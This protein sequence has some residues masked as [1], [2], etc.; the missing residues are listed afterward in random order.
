[1][2]LTIPARFPLA[3]L[4]TPLV[5]ARRLE[6]ALGSPPIYIKRDDLA[7]F[8]SAG[9]KA[10]KLEFI[11][12]DALARGSDVLVTGGGPSSNHCASA[13]RACRVAGLD[14][15]L[16]LYGQEPA[17]I[18]PNLA[19]ACSMGAQVWFTNDPDRE[20]VDLA[21]PEAA[22]E[23]E[24]KGRRP[25]LVPRGGATALGAVGCALAARELA[26]QLDREGA[27][28]TA[29]VVATGSCGTQA[30][31]VS[32][33]AAHEG[34]W[35]VVGASVSRPVEEC[36]RRVLDLARGCASLMGTP[37]PVERH[38]E[39]ID[40]RGPGFG[41]GSAEGAE[42]ARLAARTE[43]LLLDPTYTAKAFAL[44]IDLA[45]A[46]ARGTMVFIHTGGDPAAIWEPGPVRE[47]R[48][49]A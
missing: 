23:L 13:A 24:A 49:L 25:Y 38:V 32:A 35:R 48:S 39:V 26:A 47:E 19:L 33:A 16:V 40:A 45:R 41:L 14:C 31:L 34:S 30:G 3:V 15:L 37:E 10:R 9:N 2:A 18:H 36:S 46:G 4:P 1:V 7:G 29:V 17:E 21:L 6:R 12:A 11:I 8:G 20:S 44:L 5:R 28:A 22:A 42:A 43:G 27:H